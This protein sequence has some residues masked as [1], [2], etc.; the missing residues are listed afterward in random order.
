MDITVKG[1]QTQNSQEDIQQPLLQ[2][3]LET[4]E[5]PSKTNTQKAIRKTFKGT[6]HLSSLLPTGSVLVFE[7][8]SPIFTNKGKCETPQNQFLTTALLIFCCLS[9]FFMC[10]TDSVRDEKGKVRYGI[11][12]SKGI[13]IVDGSVTLAEEAAAG[14]RLRFLDWLHAVMSILVFMAVALFDQNVVKCFYPS[15][16]EETQK[17]LLMVPAGI[18]IVCSLFFVLFPSK[19]HGVTRPLSRR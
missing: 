18:G 1:E 7:I 15:P 2:N 14:Y 3:Q 10:F 4:P 17:L 13:W 5:K 6:A 19:R 11:A 12:T 16:S 9:C 8:F